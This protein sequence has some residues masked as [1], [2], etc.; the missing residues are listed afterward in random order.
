ML[1]NQGLSERRFK[2]GPRYVIDY[3]GYYYATYICAG[4]RD[5]RR[6][7]AGWVGTHLARR[8][9]GMLLATGTHLAYAP[10]ATIK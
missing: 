1:L 2:T 9:A 4:H 6:A 8:R 10:W 3:K 5:M 7:Y